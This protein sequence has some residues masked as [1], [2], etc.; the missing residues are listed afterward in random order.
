MCFNIS[1]NQQLAAFKKD[2]TILAPDGNINEEGYW[3]FREWGCDP[4]TLGAKAK[5]LM[6]LAASF[7]SDHPEMNSDRFYVM[8]TNTSD[9][10]D[11]SSYEINIA[12]VKGKVYSL[13]TRLASNE[14]Q[15]VH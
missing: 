10:N 2:G 3:N 9:K 11:F 8:F 7:A 12:D 4:S 13:E 6:Q 5:V 15:P 14:L 1:F